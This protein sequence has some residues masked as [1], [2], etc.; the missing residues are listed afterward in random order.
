MAAQ[1]DGAIVGSAIVE[2]LCRT[3]RKNCVPY[4]KTVKS[5]KTLC[6]RLKQEEYKN[7]KEMLQFF[8]KNK[9]N[10][11]KKFSLF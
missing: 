3:W 1:S 2:N 10:R 5:I 8:S 6:V 11:P 9:Q 4:V 7:G